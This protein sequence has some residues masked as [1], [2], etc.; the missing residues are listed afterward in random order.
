MV[1]YRV[2]ERGRGDAELLFIRAGRG[3]GAKRCLSGGRG[4]GAK[5]G[6]VFYRGVERGRVDTGLFIG[7]GRGVG[8]TRGGGFSGQG[9]G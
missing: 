5:R 4:V 1:V 3:V 9:E 8:A 6:C 2:G 7:V